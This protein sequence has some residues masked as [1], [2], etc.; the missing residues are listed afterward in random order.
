MTS[1]QISVMLMMY[2]IM[3]KP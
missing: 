1:E 3:T 2:M